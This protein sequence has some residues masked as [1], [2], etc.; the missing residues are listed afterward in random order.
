[1]AFGRWSAKTQR[2]IIP[3]VIYFVL[4]SSSQFGCKNDSDQGSG[5]KSI[6]DSCK[7]VYSTL[8]EKLDSCNLLEAGESVDS[9]KTQAYSEAGCDRE[10]PTICA[11][12]GKKWDIGNAD[13]CIPEV[14]SLSCGGFRE[15]LLGER[16]IPSCENICK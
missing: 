14:K 7:Q 5:T 10:N 3:A 2:H 6:Q 1:M 13:K 4:L 12:E 11:N 16:T 15:L 8:C 9:C